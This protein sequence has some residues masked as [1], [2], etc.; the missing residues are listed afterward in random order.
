MTIPTASGSFVGLFGRTVV[1]ET[2][3]AGSLRR[4]LGPR[5]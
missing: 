3:D 2:D 5:D 1:A 4:P